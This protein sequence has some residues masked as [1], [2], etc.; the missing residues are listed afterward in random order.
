LDENPGFH[1]ALTIKIK[2]KKKKKE[3]NLLD[4]F[5]ETKADAINTRY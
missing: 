5:F 3:I 4:F 1:T 2:G